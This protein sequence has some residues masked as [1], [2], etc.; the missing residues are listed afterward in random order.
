MA[1]PA[2]RS[3]RRMRALTRVVLLALAAVLVVVLAGVA[4]LLRATGLT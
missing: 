1:D 2:D 3:A 4:L